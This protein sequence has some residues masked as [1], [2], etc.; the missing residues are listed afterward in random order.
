MPSSP[1]LHPRFGEIVDGRL[2][3]YDLIPVGTAVRWA[4]GAAFKGD[5]EVF[6]PL[7]EVARRRARARREKKGLKRLLQRSSADM[8]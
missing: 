1:D 8:T 7:F 5:A 6:A 2:S 4:A 3:P